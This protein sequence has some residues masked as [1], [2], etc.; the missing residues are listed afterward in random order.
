MEFDR[1]QGFCKGLY[2]K[3]G[4]CEFTFHSLKHTRDEVTIKNLQYSSSEESVS[5]RPML[6]VH[7]TY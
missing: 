3:D 4:G 5:Y 6:T 7:Y 1:S 2:I